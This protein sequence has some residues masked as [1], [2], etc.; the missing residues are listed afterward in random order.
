MKKEFSLSKM[1][2]YLG[3]NPK[4][5]DF[6]AYWDKK[7]KLLDKFV[8]KVKIKKIASKE[9]KSL[10]LMEVTF[11]SFDGASI[12]AKYLRPKTDRK[13]P[14]VLQFHGYPGSS[15]SYFELSAF[16]S[17]GLAVLAMD[18]RGQGGKSQDL[19]GYKGTTVAGH[20]MAGID[21]AN[22]DNLLYT[23]IFQDVALMP[24]VASLL[25]G[26]DENRIYVNGASQGG[27][28]AIVCA[29]L[30]RQVKK[31]AILYPFLSDYQRVFELEYDQIA[32]EGLRYYSRWMD[33]QG[34]NL[35]YWFDKLGYIDTKNFAN[36]IKCPVLFGISLADT[37]C[38]PST[39]FAVYNNLNTTKQYFAYEGKGHE[40][41]HDFDDKIIPFFLN[42]NLNQTIKAKSITYKSGKELKQAYL[43]CKGNRPLIVFFDGLVEVKEH[44]LL[45]FDA[46]GYD[47]VSIPY[48]NKKTLKDV[49]TILKEI[50][51]I[52]EI[53]D[54][55]TVGESYGATLAIVF[56]SM[57]KDCKGCIVQSPVIIEEKELNPIENAKRI[58][59]PFLLASGKIDKISLLED[60]KKI[61]KNVKGKKEHLQYL[62]YDHE[63]INDFEDKK[64][65]FLEKLK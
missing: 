35:E 54:I 20:I 61:F 42:K 1:K 41:I 5:I 34:E 25:S 16:A 23:K 60:N 38:P 51:R 57:I 46:I 10:E 7:I 31:A 33:P 32:Y 49:S 17:E 4:P 8:P 55:V 18:C 56:A 44:Y 43:L 15:R 24:K 14:C 22:L 64:M 30:S 28:L 2:K 63:R 65:H 62:R 52:M 39:Q 40:T 36:K 13:V 12:N 11:K 9:F 53:K 48:N 45:R 19:G 37:V 6:D 47:V 59:C 50:E 26:I 27:A 58:N 29:A 21:D 3:T